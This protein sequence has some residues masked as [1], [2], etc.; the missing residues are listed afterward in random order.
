MTEPADASE[1]VAKSSA[2]HGFSEVS[3][4]MAAVPVANTTS[5]AIISSGTAQ[6]TSYPSS[7]TVKSSLPP[8]STSS[9]SSPSHDFQFDPSSTTEA[10]STQPSS[11][12]GTVAAASDHTGRGCRDISTRALP[13]HNSAH[14]MKS[15]D[16]H[17][18]SFTVHAPSRA[19]QRIVTYDF[20]QDVGKSC[21][22]V[23]LRFG[24][25]K[26]RK[27]SSEAEIKKSLVV[28]LKYGKGTVVPV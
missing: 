19:T 11:A 20:V 10:S 24:K 2:Y 7:I 3:G 13:H 5:A 16:R 8:G 21:S 18:T 9:T 26:C 25:D 22:F 4:D 6:N 27:L 1:R 23:T 14:Q 28:T 12:P 17:G 15:I